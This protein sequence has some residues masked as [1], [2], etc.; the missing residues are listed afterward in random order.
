MKKLH[1]YVIKL[2][3]H[4]WE[5]VAC[6]LEFEIHEIKTIKEKIKD[7]DPSKCCQEMLMLWISEDK[8]KK[9]K[10]WRSLLNELDDIDELK[11]YS[12]E[13]KLELKKK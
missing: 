13:I 1:K 2:I 10:T 5:K 8:G 11:E 6:F 3:S 9:D 4:M 12:K 7:C